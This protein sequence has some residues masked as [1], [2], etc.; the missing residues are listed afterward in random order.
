MISKR[1]KELIVR[2]AAC[3]SEGYS[4]FN[5]DWLSENHVTLDECVSLSELIGTIIK[6]FA[7]SDDALQFDVFVASYDL[8]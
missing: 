6:G 1:M 4:P 8:R 7:L 5:N 3:F 2:A